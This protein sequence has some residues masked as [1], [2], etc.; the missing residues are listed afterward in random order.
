MPTKLRETWTLVSER[1]GKTVW[2][3]YDP[4][5]GN[6]II[7]ETWV[8]DGALA[9]A[10]ALRDIHDGRNG[11]LVPVGV[12]PDSVLAR[13]LREGWFHDNAKW[14]QFFNDADHSRLRVTRG[15]Y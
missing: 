4:E 10:A 6:I 11:D 9:E 15:H 12:I 8:D 14:K 13:S 7:R 3:R 5:T 2:S 1:A